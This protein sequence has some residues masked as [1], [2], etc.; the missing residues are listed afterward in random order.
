M[1]GLVEAWFGEAFAALD[2]RLRALH[3]RGGTLR[4]DVEVAFGRGI[5]GA[6]GRRIARRLGVP[7]TSGA[8]ALDVDIRSARIHTL[9]ADVVDTFYVTSAAGGPIT[10]EEHRHEIER[11]LLHALEPVT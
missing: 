10:D 1:S 5:A 4:G 2:P 11:A 9:G 8:H 7:T 3:Q 6:I